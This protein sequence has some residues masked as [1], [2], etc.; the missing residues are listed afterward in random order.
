MAFKVFGNVFQQMI[1]SDRILFSS[2]GRSKTQTIVD[3][4]AYKALPSRFCPPRLSAYFFLY[5]H[6]FVIPF[7]IITGVNRSDFVQTVIYCPWC[8]VNWMLFQVRLPQRRTIHWPAQTKAWLALASQPI[9]IY[10]YIC[11][12]FLRSGHVTGGFAGGADYVMII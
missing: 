5:I 8:L 10:I 1:T 11:I 12:R 2:Y 3:D 4:T 9:Y 6:I 7:R